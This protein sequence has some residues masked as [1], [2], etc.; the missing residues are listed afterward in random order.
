MFGVE[1]MRRQL[2]S[3]RGNVGGAKISSVMALAKAQQRIGHN[4][5][6]CL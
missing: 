3:Q 6:S 1:I 5:A 2:R 4:E